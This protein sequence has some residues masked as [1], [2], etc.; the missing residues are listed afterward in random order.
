MSHINT[1]FY[2]SYRTLLNRQYPSTRQTD[3]TLPVFPIIISLPKSL[4]D[5]IKRFVRTIYQLSRQASYAKT[6]ENMETEGVEY[7]KSKIKNYS[8]LM[9]YDFHLE[10]D[11]KKLKL[12]EVNTNGSGYLISDL[13][14]QL[15]KVNQNSLSKLKK[16][17]MEEWHYF[18]KNDPANISLIDENI[19]EQKMYPEFLM[20][21]DWFSTWGWNMNI[22]EAEKLNKQLKQMEKQDRVFG[23]IYNRSVDF[24]LKKFS[25][26]KK[27]FLD[28]NIC[29]TP[30]PRE[31]FLLSDKLRMPQWTDPS[32]LDSLK[33]DKEDKELILDTVPHSRVIKP[34]SP[35]H[36]AELWKDRKK[37]FFKPLSGYGGRG[38]FKGQ[39]ITKKI[40]D[41]FSKTSFLIQQIVK[42]DVFVDS[43][44][45]QEWKYDLRAYA[46]RGEVQKV[47]ARVYQGQLTNFR[48]P[49]SGFATVSFH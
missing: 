8:V 20:F 34:T 47:A 2:T 21:K 49:G 23:L 32:F 25:Y 30:H 48:T 12:I 29:L 36:M 11:T 5:R 19:S 26:I 4:L 22:T 24:Y 31:Y 44:L 38:V 3:H 9:A 40:F 33:V 41:Q 7:L 16:S 13:L 1:S 15:H 37:Y 43:R 35:S 18:S 6:L 17:F 27:T 46:Y 45:D 10:K 39:T 14:D 28:Q 42:P